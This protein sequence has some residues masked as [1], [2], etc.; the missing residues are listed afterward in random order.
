MTSASGEVESQAG[1]PLSSIARRF[2]DALRR[3]VLQM[4]Q[5]AL[6]LLGTI[7]VL[8]FIFVAIFG[9]IIAPYPYAEI[10]DNAIAH[11]P[12]PEY[13]FGVDKLGRDVFS[14]VIWGTRDIVGLPGIA[15]LIS[16]F[17]G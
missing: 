10:I 2:K 11:P 17:L 4:A 15:T 13:P 6:G 14:R 12:S 5:R 1:T 8:V 3:F 9:P 7:L 16:V